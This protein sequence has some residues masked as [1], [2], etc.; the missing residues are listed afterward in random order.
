M[1]SPGLSPSPNS[2]AGSTFGK[3]SDLLDPL[4]QVAQW[5]TI[6]QEDKPKAY[7]IYLT[8]KIKG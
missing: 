3:Y 2:D 7:Q 5:R 1:F 6:K 4:R 8:N